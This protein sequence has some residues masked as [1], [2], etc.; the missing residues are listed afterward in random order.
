MWGLEVNTAKTKIVVFRRRGQIRVNEQ[1]TY[2]NNHLEVV[3]DFKKFYARVRLMLLLI[4][5]S[6]S[7]D[8]DQA[9]SACVVCTF[10]FSRFGKG[11]GGFEKSI[12]V[13]FFLRQFCYSS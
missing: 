2:H 5:S 7:A 6:C 9:C 11:G 1:W 8:A 12:L 3:D 13:D 4:S 10:E